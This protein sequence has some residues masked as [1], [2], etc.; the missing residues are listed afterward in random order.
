MAWID[1]QRLNQGYNVWKTHTGDLLS[2]FSWDSNNPDNHQNNQNCLA[3][4]FHENGLVS[5]NDCT[6]GWPSFCQMPDSG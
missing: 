2:Y 3:F 1:G 4:R 5:D 6:H